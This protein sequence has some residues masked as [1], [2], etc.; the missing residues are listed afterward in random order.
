M[1]LTILNSQQAKTARE[2][3]GISQ[4]K[5]ASEL[6]IN[7]SYLSQFES[8]KRLLADKELNLLREY[9]EENG[10]EFIDSPTNEG[11]GIRIM[12]GFALPAGVND[13]DADIILT[14]YAENME[15]IQLLSEK[16]IKINSGIFSDS[17]DDDDKEAKTRQLLCLMARN[18][19]LIEQLQGRETI[20]PCPSSDI[21][22]VKTTTS[23]FISLEFTEIFG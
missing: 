20:S 5:L 15:K 10:Y 23:E 6:N 7:R 14:E 19:T 22:K 4:G 21:A 17:I 1:Q 13:M 2:T 9:Y 8:G 16:D 3:L 11:N 12:D 18:Y